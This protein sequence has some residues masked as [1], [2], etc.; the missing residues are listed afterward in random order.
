MAPWHCHGQL[1][2]D[3]QIHRRKK[4]ATSSHEENVRSGVINER[5]WQLKDLTKTYFTFRWFLSF[6]IKWLK[7][8][9]TC[10]APH[11]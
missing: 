8:V 3:Q 5:I 1:L 6:F 7:H 4:N 10:E 9:A 2:D 11:P